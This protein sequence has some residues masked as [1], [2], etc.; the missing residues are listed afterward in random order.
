MK[1]VI[2]AA[3][4]GCVS[5]GAGNSAYAESSVKATPLV[6]IT[7]SEGDE[8]AYLGP[9]Y[10]PNFYKSSGES[11]CGNYLK[12]TLSKQK[13]SKYIDDENGFKGG[14]LKNCKFCC[15]KD[16][17]GSCGKKVSCSSSRARGIDVESGE[18][19]TG[20]V[21]VGDDDY[22]NLEDLSGKIEITPGYE[23]SSKVLFSWT[24]RVEGSIPKDCD[25]K[26][27]D[28]FRGISV[29]PVL[30]HP[31]HGTSHQDYEGGQVKT[32]L[33]IR[34]KGEDAYA[35]VGNPVEMTVPPTGKS[36]VHVTT[37]SDPTLSGSYVVKPSDFGGSLPNEIEYTL[38]WANHTALRLKSPKKQRN[39]VVMVMP[40]TQ[41][42]N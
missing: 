23:E 24:V 15:E 28:T 34:V 17:K 10:F 25:H 38:K 33:Y 18:G 37:K 26:K 22:Y 42:N 19:K 14:S 3:V 16:E 40:L 39:L 27:G 7:Q 4:I 41:K 31:W 12:N 30:C 32:Q 13:M 11:A 5:F 35:A 1:R 8:D 20:K 6:K 2:L 9:V 29:W 21:T 36:K